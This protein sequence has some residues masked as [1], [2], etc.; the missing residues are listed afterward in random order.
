MEN[1]TISVEVK[2]ALMRPPAIMKPPVMNGAQMCVE[3]GDKVEQFL[4]NQGI[5]ENSL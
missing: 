5:L 2:P 4:K 3:S 1:Q